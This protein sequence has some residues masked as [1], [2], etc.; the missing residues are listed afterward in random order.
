MGRNSGLS[1]GLNKDW[2][3]Q[4]IRQKRKSHKTAGLY[5]NVA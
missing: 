2:I 4:L 3:M 1:S 5:G